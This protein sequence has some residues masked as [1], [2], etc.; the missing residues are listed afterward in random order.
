MISASIVHFATFSINF[1]EWLVHRRPDSLVKIPY[2]LTPIESIIMYPSRNLSLCELCVLVVALAFLAQTA[3]PAADAS[4]VRCFALCRR[5]EDSLC[6]QC[7]FREPMRFGKRGGLAPGV[8]PRHLVSL[9]A[10]Q[11]PLPAI[12][13]LKRAAFREPMRFGKRADEDP[14]DMDWLESDER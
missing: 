9:P 3:L 11:L 13:D 5:N 7:M 10:W 1:D 2:R 8:A 14:T 6:R 12:E 4:P